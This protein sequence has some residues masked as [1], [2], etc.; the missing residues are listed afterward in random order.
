ML[1]AVE[2]CVTISR[3]AQLTFDFVL[4]DD[5]AKPVNQQRRATKA[6]KKPA[7]PLRQPPAAEDDKQQRIAVACNLLYALARK[8]VPLTDFKESAAFICCAKVLIDAGV[9]DSET[10]VNTTI[11]EHAAALVAHAPQYRRLRNSAVAALATIADLEGK[12]PAKGCPEYQKGMR[13][14]YR[15]ASDIAAMFLEDMQ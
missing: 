1:M 7:Q 8:F 12:A 2:E 9:I 10:A 3:R 14:A 11:E 15:H 6:K 4:P 13:A 5:T